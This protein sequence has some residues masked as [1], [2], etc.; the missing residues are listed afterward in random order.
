MWHSQGK[1]VVAAAGTPE[2][3]TA[4][5]TIA[6]TVFFQQLEGNIGKI[7]ICDRA[8]ANKITGV[9]V[10]AVIPAPTLSGGVAVVLPYAS[11]TVPSA[12]AALDVAQ[13]WLDMDNNGEGCQISYVV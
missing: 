11:V 5:R 3:I 13:F 6:Q 10:L 4:I 9:G 8:T 1:T 12:P 7:W 2:R